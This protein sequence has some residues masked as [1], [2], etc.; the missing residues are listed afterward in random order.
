[1]A[2]VFLTFTFYMF[3]E[4]CEHF[5][6]IPYVKIMATLLALRME[7]L[8]NPIEIVVVI[9]SAKKSKWVDICTEVSYYERDYVFPFW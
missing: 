2:S 6:S 9:I 3:Y 8:R 1:M 4:F 5:K 7:F